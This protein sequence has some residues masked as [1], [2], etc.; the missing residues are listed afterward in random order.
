MARF[1]EENKRIRE[2]VKTKGAFT[3]DQSL[4]KLVYLAINDFLKS[5][6]CQCGI[7]A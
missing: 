2:N 6:R 5:G 7:G 3:S 4:L 1:S